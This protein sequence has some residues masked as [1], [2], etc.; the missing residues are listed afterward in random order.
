MKQ[1]NEFL[2]KRPA[3]RNRR[4]LF[5]LSNL[6]LPVL[7]VLIGLIVSTQTFARLVGYN[8]KYTDAPVFVTGS[9]FLFI[10]EG[11]PF[12]NPGLIFLNVIS[13]GLTDSLIQSI[14]LQ[15]LFPFLV[16][17]GLG[18]LCFFVISAIRG[19][20]LNKNEKL[21]GSAR[22]G[23]EKDIKKFGLSE[24]RGVVLAEFQK[25]DVRA[26]VNPKNTSIQ[27]SL[28]KPAP[29]I[30]I[31]GNTMQSA[32]CKKDKFCF[33]YYFNIFIFVRIFS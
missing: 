26:K 15:A 29:L 27:L 5:D 19:Y 16:S 14:I 1:N 10:D 11:Y 7:V 30:C 12:Y 2:R 32:S 17:A 9:R 25:A 6:V 28:K 23:N 18:I 24:K 22:W 3:E 33:I 21:Y 8:P 13:K 4:V 31:A 20:G